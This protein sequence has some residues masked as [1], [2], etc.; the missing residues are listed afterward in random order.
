MANGIVQCVGG[1]YIGRA[2]I[3]SGTS[4]TGAKASKF[5]GFTFAQPKHRY[6]PHD[7]IRL[8]EMQY[9]QAKSFAGTAAAAG[10]GVWRH[11]PVSR[12]SCWRKKAVGYCVAGFF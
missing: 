2:T 7:I 9:E 10:A 6:L 4:L 1:H 12:R 11:W 8:T 5:T 3:Q